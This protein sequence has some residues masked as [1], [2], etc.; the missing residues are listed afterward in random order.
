MLSLNTSNYVIFSMQRSGTSSFCTHLNQLNNT[1]CYYE[2]LSCKDKILKD[3]AYSCS[4][5]ER[6]YTQKLPYSY[7]R[8]LTKGNLSNCYC[9]ANNKHIFL[10]KLKEIYLKNNIKFGYKIF[11]GHIAHNELKFILDKN[12][13]CIVLKRENVTAQYLS[14]KNPIQSGCWIKTRNTSKCKENKNKTDTID[15]NYMFSSFLRIYNNWFKTSFNVCSKNNIIFIKS[16]D[17]FKYTTL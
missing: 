15:D 3:V 16:E 1:M 6:I 11:P 5:I 14:L 13:T 17:Y 12:T 4:N 10:N 9:K 7:T 8:N 2:L